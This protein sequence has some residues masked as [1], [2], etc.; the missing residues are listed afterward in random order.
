MLFIDEDKIT[1]DELAPSLQ[2]LFDV[3]GAKTKSEDNLN[4][5]GITDQDIKI[6]V[7]QVMLETDDNF[8]IIDSIDN[9]KIVVY[10]NGRKYT[11]DLT[12]A[13]DPKLKNNVF[14]YH[15]DES[16]LYFFKDNDHIIDLN[17]ESSEMLNSHDGYIM[18]ADT[19]TKSFKFSP[20]YYTIRVATD[21][22]SLAA[23]KLSPASDVATYKLDA[24]KIYSLYEDKIYERLGS[25][26]TTMST[27]L[28]EEIDS[29]VFIYD[30]IIQKMW[31]YYYWGKYIEIETKTVVT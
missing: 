6:N 3:V 21:P 1:Y 31:F 29:F 20:N 27:P 24:D 7:E 19:T 22:A 2:A 23:C 4:T 9:S 16:R 17:Q 11:H 15:K 25:S 18:K 5:N 13:S 30:P 26:W 8:H 14:L 12:G 28:R 10:I